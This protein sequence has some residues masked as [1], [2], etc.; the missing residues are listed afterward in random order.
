MYC[1]FLTSHCKLLEFFLI[2]ASPSS[3]ITEP[4][5]SCLVLLET[6]LL[7]RGACKQQQTSKLQV[8]RTQ[9]YLLG[10]SITTGLE[11]VHTSGMCTFLSKVWNSIIRCTS[12]IS[13]V[14]LRATSHMSQDLWPC[15]G[16]DPWL[17]SKGHTVGVGRAVLCSHGPSSIVWSESGPC[18]GTIACLV[19]G[20]RGEDL[21]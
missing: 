11:K 17:S 6:F 21:V 15:N 12:C 14:S 3:K 9:T 5:F 18:C 2:A 19:G 4:L 7:D 1:E 10:I 8:F 13:G 20:K 16:E